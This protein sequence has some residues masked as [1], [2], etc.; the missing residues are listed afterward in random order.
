MMN[1]LVVLLILILV[2]I[3]DIEINP[4]LITPTAQLVPAKL[5]K[6]DITVVFIG[7]SRGDNIISYYVS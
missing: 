1:I 6:F 7:R 3:G 5:S 4:G 2:V